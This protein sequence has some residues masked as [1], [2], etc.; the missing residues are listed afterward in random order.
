MALLEKVQLLQYFDL[1]GLLEGVSEV[2]D[3]IYQNSQTIPRPDFQRPGHET[4][5]SHDIHH[6]VLIQGAVPILSATQR[7]NGLVQTNALL[8]GLIRNLTQ[9]SRLPG[10]ILVLVEVPLEIHRGVSDPKSKDH[11]KSAR[12]QYDVEIY[13]AF[14]GPNGEDLRLSGGNSIVSQT[15]VN[16]FDCLVLVHD[17][18]SRGGYSTG[19]R[20]GKSNMIVEVGKDRVG[21][22][23][24][25]WA[26]WMT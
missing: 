7:R 12:G 8:A 10:G 19:E 5:R 11:A 13:S 2:N 21:N 3:N 23:T 24:G 20:N 14:S 16:S 4:Q 6:I 9:L 18:F 1:A 26:E 25:L 15:L 22:M 17:A